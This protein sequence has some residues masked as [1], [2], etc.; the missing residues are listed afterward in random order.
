MARRRCRGPQL[1]AAGRVRLPA[2]VWAAA[3]RR[4]PGGGRPG[5]RSG[6]GGLPGTGPAVAAIGRG[7]RQAACRLLAE[8]HQR[9]ANQSRADAAGRRAAEFPADLNWPDPLR[10]ELAEMRTGK[11]NWLRQA[12][13]YNR[14]GHPAEALALLQHTV[15]DYPD[16]D[17]GW[18]ALGRAFY[19]RKML[20]PAEGAL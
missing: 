9:L 3:S 16:A 10:D 7:L 19:E 18:F 17:D 13:A 8:V 12:E 20:E 1:A 6:R 4:E 15:R 14:E 11:A 5:C 2:L